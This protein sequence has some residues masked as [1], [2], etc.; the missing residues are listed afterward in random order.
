MKTY[1]II[2]DTDQDVDE[3]FA[4]MKSECDLLV[5][6]GGVSMG[7]KD[8]IKPFLEANGEVVFG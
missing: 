5:T 7:E 1:G 8:L 3:I 6:S 4:R 2:K